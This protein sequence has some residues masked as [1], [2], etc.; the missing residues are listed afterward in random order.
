MSHVTPVP[1][2]GQHRFPDQLVMSPALTNKQTK[3]AT[4]K[5]VAP[6]T[7][8]GPIPVIDQHRPPDH[9]LVMWSVLTRMR[10][11]KKIAWRGGDIN[12]TY[13]HKTYIPSSQ[14][15]G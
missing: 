5:P 11:G 15:L 12:T 1:F 3:R 4:K 9:Q 8:I 14:L 10:P 6:I 2:I 7:G 13:I